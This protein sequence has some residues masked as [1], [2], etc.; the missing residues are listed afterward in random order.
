MLVGLY[1]SAACIVLMHVF[2]NN[3][4]AFLLFAVLNSVAI[5][6]AFIQYDKLKDRIEKLEHPQD[7]KKGGAE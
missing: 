2:E 5:N 7:E 4:W 1:I 3:M 6:F